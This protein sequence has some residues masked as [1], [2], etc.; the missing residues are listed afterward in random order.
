MHTIM[1][2]DDQLYWLRVALENS[3]ESARRL[4]G[5]VEDLMDSSLLIDK[6]TELQGIIGETD[7]ITLE[8]DP[9]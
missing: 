7:P 8:D 2:T 3:L 9:E 6:Y 5:D 4:G 1:L